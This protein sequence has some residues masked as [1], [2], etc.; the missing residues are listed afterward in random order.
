MITVPNAQAE[1]LWTA[2][3]VGLYLKASRSWVYQKAEAGVIPSVRIFG[4]LRFHPEAIRAFAR[5]PIPSGRLLP[6]SGRAR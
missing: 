3:D 4:L 5:E 1:P 6:L 2:D